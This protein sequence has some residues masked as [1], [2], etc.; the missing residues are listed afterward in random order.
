M[1]RSLEVEVEVAVRKVV[2]V[3][4]PLTRVVVVVVVGVHQSYPRMKCLIVQSMP[5]ALVKP[6]LL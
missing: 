4:A 1:V 3:E 5:R 2:V 6:F